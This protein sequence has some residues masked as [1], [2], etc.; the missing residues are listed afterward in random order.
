MYQRSP[1]NTASFT[2]VPVNI[3]THVFIAFLFYSL[4]YIHLLHGGIHC[5]MYQGPIYLLRKNKTISPEL[6]LWKHTPHHTEATFSKISKLPRWATFCA[7]ARVD[8]LQ[9]Q[10][11]EEGTAAAGKCSRAISSLDSATYDPCGHAASCSSEEEKGETVILEKGRR[12]RKV[13]SVSAVWGSMLWVLC[14]LLQEVRGPRNL[15]C[16]RHPLENRGSLWDSWQSAVLICW[17]FCCGSF[18]FLSLSS[19]NDPPLS[20]VSPA[21]SILFLFFGLT[22]TL[23]IPPSA[24]FCIAVSSAA[25]LFSTPF[26]LQHPVSSSARILTFP[27]LKVLPFNW[28]HG[29]GTLPYNHIKPSWGNLHWTEVKPSGSRGTGLERSLW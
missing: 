20:F 6:H 24:S 25:T 3:C 21:M 12:K 18:C 15:C 11:G 28:D 7:M 8:A 23:A 16:L 26:L 5:W 22:D 19:A 27:T 13:W 9:K 2:T 14:S 4:L 10:P 29:S 1:D 17:F